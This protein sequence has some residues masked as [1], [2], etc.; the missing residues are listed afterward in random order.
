VSEQATFH[1]Q[2]QAT[3]NSGDDERLSALLT[4]ARAADIAEAFQL[5][6]DE[7]RSKLFFALPPHTA[8]EVV[9]LLDEAVRSDVVEDLDTQALTDLVQELAPDDAA[10]V[11]AEL[12]PEA[13]GQILDRIEAEKSDQVGQLLRYPPD[14]AGGIMTPEV[15]AIPGTKTVADAVEY[16]R[17]ASQDEELHEIYVV[18]DERKL[19]GTVPLRRLVTSP[20]SRKLESIADRDAVRVFADDHQE[21]VV[22]DIRKYDAIAAAVVD[23]DGRLLGRI[24][25]DDLLDVAEEEAA[26]DL[27]R[28]AGTD[29]AELETSSVI[30]AARIRL[31]WLLPCMVGTLVTASVLLITER[32][33]DPV[34]FTALAAFVPMIGAMSGNSGIQISTVIV[35]GF[36]TGEL[37]STRLQ[38]AFSR[39]GR[40]VGAMAPVCGAFAWL[41]ATI[42]LSALHSLGGSAQAG[43]KSAR[44]ALAIGAAMTTAILVSGGLGV[45]LPFL[46]RK[47][48]IDPAIASGPLVTTLND[49]V[50]VSIY[51]LLAVVIVT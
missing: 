9:I 38:R 29:A 15:V 39:E 37:A 26:E 23:R 2:L 34:L 16:V 43:E 36:A 47:T 35:R 49:V 1:D 24:T 3:L 28:M 12:E 48:G 11:L 13:A 6:S 22:Q 7:E 18:D 30:H 31:T 21:S 8:A 42:G 44:I 40:I 5:L 32:R 19:I 20:P 14:T 17:V 27:F 25:N 46:F 33:F 51:M 45:G 10:D 50:A 4:G 41:L